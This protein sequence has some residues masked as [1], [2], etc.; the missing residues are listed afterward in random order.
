MN[1]K[2]LGFRLPRRTLPVRHRCPHSGGPGHRIADHLFLFRH[3]SLRKGD[4]SGRRS[5]FCAPARLGSQADQRAGRWRFRHRRRR[6]PSR[7][8][9]RSAPQALPRTS[10]EGPASDLLSDQRSRHA[11]RGQPQRP[12]HLRLRRPSRRSLR[13]DLRPGRSVP[14]FHHATQDIRHCPSSIRLRFRARDRRPSSRPQPQA[15]PVR[16]TSI[17]SATPCAAAGAGLRC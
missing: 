2:M 16:E 14:G 7:A 12:L 10:R 15:L 6:Q 5:G 1:Y 3:S 4:L 8:G 17:R 13:D 11:G 9:R